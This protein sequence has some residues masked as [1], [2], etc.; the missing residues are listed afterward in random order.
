MARES[1]GANQGIEAVVTLVDLSHPLVHG[2]RGFPSDPPVSIQPHA[3]IAT[4][5][6]NTSVLSF[7]SHQGTHLDAMAHFIA[8]GRTIEQMPLEW[9]YGPARVLRVPRQAGGMIDTRDLRPFERWLVPEAKIIL[10]TGWHARFGQPEFFTGFPSITVDA[11]RYLASRKIRLLGMDLPTP[12]REWLDLHHVLLA[13]DVEMVL[14]EGLAALDRVPDEFV[15]AGF[16]LHLPGRDG[17][18]IR[19]V[20]I[21]G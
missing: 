4:H 17:S 11:A 21:C 2:A 16:P 14:V 15:F 19:A 10:D 8:D 6:F 1:P 13:R 3:R 12:G 18:P 7:G 5:Q 20:A 9:F